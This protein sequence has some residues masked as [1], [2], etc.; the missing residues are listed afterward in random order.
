[1][2]RKWNSPILTE[3]NG[4]TNN[5]ENT[6]CNGSRR[7]GLVGPR[8]AGAGSGQPAA[9][10]SDSGCGN[11]SCGGGGLF[12]R[13]HNPNP[14]TPVSCAC[15]CPR[16]KHVLLKKICTTECPDTKCHVEEQ[17]VAPKCGHGHGCPAPC[18]PAAPGGQII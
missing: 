14:C 7:D 5:E 15:G 13:F 6:V 11:G 8:R 10:D 18:G 1:M 3:R 16:H 2:P 12:E 4:G 17:V 9:R